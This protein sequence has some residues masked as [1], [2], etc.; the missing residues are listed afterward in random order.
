MKFKVELVKDRF[1]EGEL[2]H[3]MMDIS[4]QIEARELRGELCEGSVR[5]ASDKIIGWYM[6]Q[7]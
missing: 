3:L 1:L 2:A 4:E 7:E 6:E 5:D